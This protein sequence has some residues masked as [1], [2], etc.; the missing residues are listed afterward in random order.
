MHRRASGLQLTAPSGRH[1]ERSEAIQ[2]LGSRETGLL[3][4]FAPRNDGPS[5]TPR[6]HLMFLK[7]KTALVTGSTSGIGLAIAKA[8][9]GE[10]ANLVINGF[11]DADEIE[12]IRVGLEQAS[13]GRA[14][15][16]SADLT[17]PE[18]IEAMMAA[19][20]AELG[21]IDIRVNN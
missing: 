4:R 7:G 16:S 19:T 9:T 5:I 12:R 18:A 10:G 14:L 21:V 1:C 13:G 8:L 20:G 11:G 3:R 17:K 2:W 15:Y 6:T